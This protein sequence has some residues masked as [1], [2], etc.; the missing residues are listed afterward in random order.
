MAP[1]APVF[2]AAFLCTCILYIN[3]HVAATL[4]LIITVCRVGVTATPGIRCPH[5]CHRSYF[6]ALSLYAMIMLSSL[7]L[8]D[9]E[10]TVCLYISMRE[11][12][13]SSPAAARPTKQ[14]GSERASTRGGVNNHPFR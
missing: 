4:L 6:I 8:R 3:L 14:A 11:L 7:Y 10:T 12:L 1:I 5:Y 2:F 9:L 13:I